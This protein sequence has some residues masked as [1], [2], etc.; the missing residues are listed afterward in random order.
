MVMAGQKSLPSMKMR[1]SIP[2]MAVAIVGGL[3]LNYHKLKAHS[4]AALSSS[5]R[6]ITVVQAR[7]TVIPKARGRIELGSQA[8]HKTDMSVDGITILNAFSQ[9]NLDSAWASKS[10]S[11]I[12]KALIRANGMKI[13]KIE[14]RSSICA[15]SGSINDGYGVNVDEI[16]SSIEGGMADVRL[17]RAGFIG[18]KSAIYTIKSS[19]PFSASFVRLVQESKP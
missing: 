5:N 2:I 11:K 18:Q 8:I 16:I 12:E 1:K 7:S 3:V 14:C 13:E 15:I 4:D 9:E 17:R 19:S 6:P 10:R